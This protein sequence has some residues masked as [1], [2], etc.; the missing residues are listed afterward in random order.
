VKSYPPIPRR[1][2]GEQAPHQMHLFDKAKTE[3]RHG[4]TEGRLLVES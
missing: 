4:E 2:R 3:E 1:P